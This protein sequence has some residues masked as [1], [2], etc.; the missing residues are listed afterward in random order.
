MCYK[1]KL[2]IPISFAQY[3]IE[4]NLQKP[5]AV[6]LHLL[7]ATNSTVSKSDHLVLNIGRELKIKDKRTVERLLKQLINLNWIGFDCTKETYHI[8]GMSRISKSHGLEGKVASCFYTKDLNNLQGF[9]VA[10]VLTSVINRRKYQNCRARRQSKT[11]TKNRD[12]AK[13]VWVATRNDYFGVSLNE[14]RTLFSCSHG[15]ASKLKALAL[16]GMFIETRKQWLILSEISKPDYHLR[17]QLNCSSNEIAGKI[18]F[19]KKGSLIQVVQQLTDEIIPKIKIRT[20]KKF[21][22]S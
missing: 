8:R 1:S 6:Y 16:K 17:S 18:R 15:K 21:G 9:L 3:V 2:Q 20:V 22:K 13:Q 19:R 14:I 7:A 4:K 12:V 10:S 5:F 11:A